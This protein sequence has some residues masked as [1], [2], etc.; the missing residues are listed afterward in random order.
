MKRVRDFRNR[1]RFTTCEHS[2]KTAWNAP[3][4]IAQAAAK[5]VKIRRFSG[6]VFVFKVSVLSVH[7]VCMG[8]YGS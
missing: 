3:E 1:T 2:R 4:K 8:R 7:C 6:L 5:K